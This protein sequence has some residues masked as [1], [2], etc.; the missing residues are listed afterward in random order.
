MKFTLMPQSA[1]MT[2]QKATQK[3]SIR[4]RLP[5][6]AILAMGTPASR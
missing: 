1:V 3:E 4:T 6:S 5:W 2:D